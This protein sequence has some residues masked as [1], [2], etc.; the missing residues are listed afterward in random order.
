MASS[1]DLPPSPTPANWSPTPRWLVSFRS[2]AEWY[3]VGEFSGPNAAAA[4]ERAVEI[5]GPAGG[6]QAERV[7]LDALLR[8]RISNAPPEG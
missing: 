3:P 7:P 5:F 6:Y 2:G 1:T 8:P 4:I